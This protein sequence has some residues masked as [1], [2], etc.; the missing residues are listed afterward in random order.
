MGSHCAWPRV[1][2]LLRLLLGS[3]HGVVPPCWHPATCHSLYLLGLLIGL[4]VSP[5]RLHEV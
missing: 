5:H 3:L 2:P 1:Q 4:N